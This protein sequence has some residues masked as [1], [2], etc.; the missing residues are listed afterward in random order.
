MV[1][2]IK[3]G[4]HLKRALSVN[5]CRQFASNSIRSIVYSDRD[6]GY[7]LDPGE[8]VLQMVRPDF[9]RL[10]QLSDVILDTK[11]GSTRS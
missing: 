5:G 9:F 11:I 6:L 2:I 7:G 1:D 4:G 8:N 3:L 10:S